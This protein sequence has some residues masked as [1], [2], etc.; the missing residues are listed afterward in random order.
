MTRDNEHMEIGDFLKI[1]TIITLLIRTEE[2]LMKMETSYMTQQ[3]IL[4]N[5]NTSI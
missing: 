4:I 1:Y 3:R 2:S 5:G